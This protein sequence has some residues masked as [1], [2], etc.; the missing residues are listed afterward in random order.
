M[1][2][3]L[4]R[5]LLTLYSLTTTILV[6]R[7]ITSTSLITSIASL[8]LIGILLGTNVHVVLEQVAPSGVV[9]EHVL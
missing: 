1:T 3:P 2:H 7:K 5:L 4:T 9:H 8:R 6:M